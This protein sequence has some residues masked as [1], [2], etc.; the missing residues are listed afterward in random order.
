MVQNPA[1]TLQ[2][3]PNSLLVAPARTLTSDNQSLW[4]MLS[5]KAHIPSILRP[6]LTAALNSADKP[7]LSD[8]IESI[9]EHFSPVILRHFGFGAR[10]FP[11]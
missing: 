10:V 3:L 7:P 6:L 8:P 9:V 5:F 2:R 11:S 4:Y 1:D